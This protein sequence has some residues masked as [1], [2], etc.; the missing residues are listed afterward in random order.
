MVKKYI[1]INRQLD[2]LKK[3]NLNIDFQE[4]ARQQL[5]EFGYYEIVTANSFPFIDSNSNESYFV[6]GT[7]FED[8]YLVFNT[9]RKL[10]NTLMLACDYFESSFRQ[11][12]VRAW[13]AEYGSNQLKYLNIAN[14]RSPRN[15]PGKLQRLITTFAKIALTS[16]DNPY[17]SS[18]EQDHNIPPWILVKGVDFGTLRSWYSL[19]KPNLKNAVIKDMLTDTLYKSLT[20]DE[21]KKLFSNSLVLINQFRNRAAHGGQIYSFAPKQNDGRP[22][23]P[24]VSSF[25]TSHNITQSDYNSGFGQTGIWTLNSVLDTLKYRSSFNTLNI[26]LTTEFNSILNIL[27]TLRRYMQNRSYIADPNYGLVE[28]TQLH[29]DT[30]EN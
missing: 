23:I 11:A 13:C 5:E 4:R 14:F 29:L 6:A 12:I 20:L 9:D 8:L 10:R 21:S 17:K 16:T 1:S 19:L 25:H 15:N 3:R 27:P 2:I 18:R 7:S 28:Y 24:Y 30:D 26:Y 22:I